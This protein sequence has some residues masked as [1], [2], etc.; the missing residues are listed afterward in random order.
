MYRLY[1]PRVGLIIIANGGCE[2]SSMTRRLSLPGSEQIHGCVDHVGNTGV[3][4]TDWSRLGSGY[5]IGYFNENINKPQSLHEFN[6]ITPE[7]NVKSPN[8]L[9]PE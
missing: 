5:S 6:V 9:F 7:F 8:K 4:E 2:V 3:Q 1:R